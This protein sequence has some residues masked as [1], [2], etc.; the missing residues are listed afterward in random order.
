[1]RLWS[2]LDF[3]AGDVV[4]CR[5]LRVSVAIEWRHPRC[6]RADMNTPGT[7]LRYTTEYRNNLI[8]APDPSQPV[9]VGLTCLVASRTSGD[10]Q[11]AK[12]DYLN[13]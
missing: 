1:M 10:Q 5:N 4:T 3:H 7:H 12:L 2:E 9:L 6:P 11:G 8:S 13:Q